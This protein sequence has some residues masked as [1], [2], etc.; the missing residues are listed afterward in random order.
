MSEL[1][2]IIEFDGV[3]KEMVWKVDDIEKDYICEKFDAFEEEIPSTLIDYM[4]D[5]LFRDNGWY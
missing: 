3:K 5:E 4:G 2:I 1:K